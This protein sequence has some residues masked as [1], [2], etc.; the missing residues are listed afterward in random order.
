MEVSALATLTTPA[1][2]INFN[3]AGDRFVFTKL[4]GLDGPE[5]RVAIDNK[6]RQDGAV[7]HA[8]YA[9][10]IHATCEG[11]VIVT[12]PADRNDAEL[13]LRNALQSI[14][15]AD[16]TFAV[17]QTGQGAKTLTV[18]NDAPLQTAIVSGTLHSFTFGLVAA[19]PVWA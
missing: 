10:A 7:V 6:S 2:T 11:W 17:T 4:D 15:Q 19:N 13:D 8:I 3:A 1:G 18:R 9:A 5:L 12:N 14:W 16:G